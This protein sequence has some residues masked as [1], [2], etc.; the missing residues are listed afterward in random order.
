MMHDARCACAAGDTA[1]F[2]R[3]DALAHIL[4]FC[5]VEAHFGAL[6]LVSRTFRDCIGTAPHAW[7]TAMELPAGL[8]LAA[9]LKLVRSRDTAEAAAC[10]AWRPDLRRLWRCTRS[11]T[12]E[13]VEDADLVALVSLCPQLKRLDVQCTYA[14]TDTSVRAAVAGCPQLEAVALGYTC[15]THASLIHMARAFPLLQELS[16]LNADSHVGDDILA[17][18]AA[19][20]P[21]MR[22][23]DVR[24]LGVTDGGI[25]AAVARWPELER[26]SIDDPPDLTVA[27]FRAIGASC[28]R[29]RA[30]EMPLFNY[31]GDDS[32]MTDACVQAIAEGCPLLQELG[33][34]GWVDLTDAALLAVAERCPQLER[35]TLEKCYQVTDAGIIAI[36]THC[37]RLRALDMSDCRLLTDESIVR[38]LV[39]CKELEELTPSFVRASLALVWSACPRLRNVDLQFASFDLTDDDV[40]LLA[41]S[42]P[43]LQS[44]WLHHCSRLTDAAVLAVAAHCPRLKELD[45]S[46]C[47]KL[48]DASLHALAVN[49]PLLGFLDVTGC[50]ALTEAGV[51]AVVRSCTCLATLRDMSNKKI[52]DRYRSELRRLG[53]LPGGWRK[54]I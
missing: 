45:V 32:G 17:A 38:G 22:V 42:C 25:A 18:L 27:A 39:H 3:G 36:A 46:F 30:L 5:S 9:H 15:A 6:P 1:W 2:P 37:P 40:A 48:T 29:L 13:D 24:C 44:L 21:R 54:R 7:H 11:V 34:T 10:E 14:V 51:M 50:R 19:T 28:P 20:C 52:T 53:S 43:G 23:L 41:Q 26:L 31:T 12:V 33:L 8:P 35:L 49:C 47:Y 4:R 16:F